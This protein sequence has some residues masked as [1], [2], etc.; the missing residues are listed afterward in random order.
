LTIEKKITEVFT[1]VVIAVLNDC[2]TIGILSTARIG[3]PSRIENIPSWVTDWSNLANRL[4]IIIGT[5]EK[6]MKWRACRDTEVVAII[7][8]AAGRLLLKG[9]IVDSVMT[10]GEPQRLYKNDT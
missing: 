4:T 9:I 6:T 8:K 1:D 7:D 3:L 2:S 5:F 10:V